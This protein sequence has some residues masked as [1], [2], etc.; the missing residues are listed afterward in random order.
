MIMK[1]LNGVRRILILIRGL[2]I[3]GNNGG[4][5]RFGIELA[6]ALDPHNF[7]VSICVFFQ[8]R[9]T[10]ERHWEDEL[11]TA[12]I[13]FFYASQWESNKNPRKYLTAVV[14]LRKQ[15]S[16]KQ[17]EL[18][19]SNFHLGTMAALLAKLFSNKVKVIHTNHLN[20]KDVKGIYSLIRRRVILDWIYPMFLDAEVCVSDGITDYRN[21]AP[22][23]KFLKKRV[24]YIPNAIAIKSIHTTN[25]SKITF[26]FIKKQYLI[27]SIGRLTEQKGYSYLLLS[28]PQVLEQIPQTDL[29][30]IGDGELHEELESLAQTLNITPYVHFLGSR[31]DAQTILSQMDLFIL[32]SLW[33]GLPTVILESM[34]Y[35]IPVIGS[36]I[37]GINDLI[38]NDQT[39]W[40]VPVANPIT[41]AQTIVKTILDP[42][43]R[44]RI[45][46]TSKEFI[47]HFSI[48]NIAH[49]YEILYN[50]VFIE[51]SYQ[52]GVIIK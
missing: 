24:Y 20:P 35:G 18:C 15:I 42:D 7:Q 51:Q 1:R 3:G 17:I 34:S 8:Y 29:I 6:K 48:S 37:P 38:T 19:H 2:D 47:D 28:M 12:R 22:G 11:R 14:N 41:L 25:K 33:E 30:I 10:I 31:I 23:I 43:S 44:K 9:T 46:L 50:N 13:D 21:N 36:D 16:D 52:G 5:D 49:Q 27:G 4:G 26:D 40:L 39:G 32:P 45:S